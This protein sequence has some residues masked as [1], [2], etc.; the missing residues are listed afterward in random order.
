MNKFSFLFLFSF[1]KTTIP[2]PAL[3]ERPAMIEP[4]VKPPARYSSVK[5]TD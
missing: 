3:T 4:K 5:I 1:N 2:I